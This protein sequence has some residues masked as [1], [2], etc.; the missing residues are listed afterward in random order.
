M[1]FEELWELCEKFYQDN[2]THNSSQEIINEMSMKIDLYRMLDK[3]EI[4]PEEIKKIKSRL[5]GEIL[6]TLTNLS[7]TDNINVF[8]ALS[9]ALQ[10]R[11]MDMYT[12]KY[13]E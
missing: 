8:E 2:D 5:F 11:S 3:K 13:Q 6:L 1:H 4:D 7:L 12:K 9:V 10:M